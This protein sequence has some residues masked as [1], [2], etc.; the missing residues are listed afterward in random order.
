MSDDRGDGDCF[1]VAAC[2]ALDIPSDE[3]GVA[4][5]QHVLKSMEAIDPKSIRVCHGFVSRPTDGY[6]HVHAWIELRMNNA[7]FVLDY[8]NRKAFFGFATR[9]RSIG[10]IN[11]DECWKYTPDAARHAMI[12]EETYGPWEGQENYAPQNDTATG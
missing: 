11:D 5:G 12:R 9:Y 8:S 4:M 10:K 1:E 3:V 2:I 6:R 7:T